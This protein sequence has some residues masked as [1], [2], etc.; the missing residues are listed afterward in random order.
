MVTADEILELLG[1]YLRG[2]GRWRHRGHAPAEEFEVLDGPGRAG[3]APVGTA[4][5]GSAS[6][7]RSPG[8]SAATATGCG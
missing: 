7:P 4:A 1:R 3:W 5:T 8:R 6:S 2:C